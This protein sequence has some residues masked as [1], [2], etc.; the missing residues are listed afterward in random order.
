[1]RVLGR[2][3]LENSFFA[4]V[5]TMACMPGELR[6]VCGFCF[7]TLQMLSKGKAI[8]PGSPLAIHQNLCGSV[9]VRDPRQHLVGE[10][11]E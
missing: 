9:S 11:G 10:H 6:P 2:I 3:K 7:Q 8:P 4:S 5:P 1:M